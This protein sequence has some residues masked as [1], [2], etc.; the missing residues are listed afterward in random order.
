VV[1]RD[2]LLVAFSGGADSTALLLALR[3]V[4]PPLGCS[5]LA[6]HVDHGLDAGSA[7][8]AASAGAIAA[9]L[10]V[11]FQLLAG[12]GPS[13]PA[14]G[15]GREAAA[16]HLRYSLLDALRLE[17][18]ARWVL[19]AHH[20]DDQAETVLLRLA[21]GSGLAG[22]AGIP[23]RHGT[24]LRPLLPFTRRQLEAAVRA[25]GESP[26]ADPTNDDLRVPRNRL[27]HRLLPAIGGPAAAARARAVASAAATLVAGLER[28][29]LAT[30][31]ELAAAR[32][33]LDALR[34]LPAELL[35]W[36]L[37][38]LHRRSGAEY[39]PRA[40]AV[41]ELRRQLRAPGSIAVDCGAGWCWRIDGRDA[42][43][44]RRAPSPPVPFAY[45]LQVPG[46]VEIREA[47]TTF[48]LSRAPVAAWMTQG[49]EGHAALDLPLAPGGQVTVRSRRPGDR[50][51]PLGS[52][53]Q[54]R[55]KDLLI[56]RKVP[57]ETRDCLP[58]LC[59]ADQ[60]A[61]VPG[62][63]IHHPFRLREGAA[64]AWIA[65]LVRERPTGANAPELGPPPADGE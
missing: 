7:A 39:P 46:G 8:R 40:V 62:V 54:R 21:Q 30:V 31:P 14:A 49:A 23:A 64:I 36:A 37:A 32:L 10:G 4:A 24:L 50:L 65:E 22:L 25:A 59:V 53:H 5:L 29:L 33:P 44:A 34:R 47:G 38:L 43:V 51:Q 41:A 20:A 3:E 57:R 55:L 1:A 58:L 26:V 56:D 15:A 17:R 11:P 16:R 6:A 18:G 52:S 27:R 42:L 60:V 45:T 48:R 9:R 28:R 19:T 12:P 2:L 63:T 35:P 61:W 13:P